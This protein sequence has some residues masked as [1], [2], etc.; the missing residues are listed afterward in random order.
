MTEIGFYHLTRSPLAQ[1]LPLLLGRTLAAGQRALVV[2]RD[3]AGLA[4]LSTAL[5]AQ[6]VWLPHGTPEDG[7]ADLQPIWLSAEAEPLNGAR[8]LFLVDGA[9]TD[10][11]K[12][13]DRV[14]D[15][16]DGNDPDAVAAARMRWKAAKEAGHGLAYW[17]QTE[18]S[19]QK[20]A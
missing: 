3:A 13:F 18:S 7:D 6:P 19:W 10:R 5:W 20:K 8:Y 17:Q 12:T 9:E 15:L 4:A 1:A 14:F 11:L 16:F 2:G